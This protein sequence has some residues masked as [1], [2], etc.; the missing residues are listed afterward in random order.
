[1][2]ESNVKTITFDSLEIKQL[3]DDKKHVQI[4]A[5]ASTFG[6]TDRQND[7]IDRGAFDESIAALNNGTKSIKLLY[8]H[9]V[10]EVLGMVDSLHIEGDNVIMQGRMVR[11]FAR[12]QEILALNDDMDA[13]SD[14]S[15]GF[16]AEGFR[17][18]GDTRIIEKLDL[19]EVSIVTIPANKKAKILELK[20]NKAA[21]EKPLKKPEEKKVEDIVEKDSNT[22]GVI[23]AESI[24]TKRE[25]EKVLRKSG[26][27]TRKA[28]EFMATFFKESEIQGEPE[29][30]VAKQGEPVDEAKEFKA[31]FAES[32]KS[33][34]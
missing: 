13:L 23:E 3:E 33:F 17:F 7:I 19:F 9:N 12:V 31:A 20:N 34:S 30:T 1:M 28:S 27:F 32:L 10:E 21:D 2:T 18:D 5:I 29:K 4:R 26:V 6:N 15:I 14:V 8:Q 25:F 24:T 11:K 22:I 16:F